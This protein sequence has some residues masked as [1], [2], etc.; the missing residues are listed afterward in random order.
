MSAPVQGRDRALIRNYVQLNLHRQLNGDGI[1]TY[2]KPCR[3]FNGTGA[4][5]ALTRKPFSQGVT[6]V[7]SG[8]GILHP[9]ARGDHIRSV[10]QIVGPCRLPGHQSQLHQAW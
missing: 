1:G 2:L 8:D 6:P 3:G 10:K 7:Y 9:P 5:A 4:D